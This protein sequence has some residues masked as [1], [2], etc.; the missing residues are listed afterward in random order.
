MEEWRPRKS[1]VEDKSWRRE[2]RGKSSCLSARSLGKPAGI[3]GW[4]SRVLRCYAA[5]QLLPLSQL[6]S[7]APSRQPE[8]PR[9]SLSSQKTS[10]RKRPCPRGRASGP[11]RSET[12]PGPKLP[13]APREQPRPPP[14]GPALL[15]PRRPYLERQVVDAAQAGLGQQLQQSQE[16]EQPEASGQPRPAGA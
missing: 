13:Q 8:D 4:G 16:R 7:F 6:E 15:G 9:H 10:L 14:P 3:A 1:D 11:N 5:G 12:P 2:G